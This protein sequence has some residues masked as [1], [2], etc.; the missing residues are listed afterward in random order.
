MGNELEFAVA[1][2]AIMLTLE[3]FAL[4]CVLVGRIRGING[5]RKRFDR[6]EFSSQKAMNALKITV[7]LLIGLAVGVVGGRWLWPADPIIDRQVVTVYYEKPQSGPST[8]HSVTVR[9]P[10]LVFAPVDTVTVTE[11]KIVKV[12]PDSTELQVAVETRPYSGP[13]WSA[14]VSGPAIGDLHPQLD[15]MKVNQQTQVVQGPLRKTRW[16][17]GVQAGYG[18]VLKQDVRLYPYI[19]VGVSYNI[20]RW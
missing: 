12:G 3:T 17:I 4:L 13:D 10:N 2:L 18:A 20:I 15:W 9:V 1:I 19:G 11:T 14:Q 7:S 16:G 8:Y 5:G 6:R